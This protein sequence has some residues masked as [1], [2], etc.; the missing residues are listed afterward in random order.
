MRVRSY[1]GRSKGCKELVLIAFRLEAGIASAL[2]KI[3]NPHKGLIKKKHNI[4]EYYAFLM[5]LE[6]FR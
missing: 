5:I 1:A 3:P 6:F 4:R 2:A